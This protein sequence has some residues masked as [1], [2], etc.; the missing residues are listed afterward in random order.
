MR[1]AKFILPLLVVLMISCGQEEIYN[2]YV[3]IPESGWNKDSVINFDVIVS[4]TSVY[5]GVVVQFRHNTDYP[6]QNL[7]LNREIS[8]NGDK[9]YSD[10]VDYTLGLPTGEWIGDGFGALKSLEMP[11]KKN[12][13]R[14]NAPGT[15]RFTFEH[16][17][18]DDVLTG[19]E[20][21]GIRIITLNDETNG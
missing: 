13:L 15:Y 5:Y 8:I 3:H 16:G 1:I 6:Y 18:R 21:F 2:E 12:A 14:F 10:H 17:M 9:I 11:Y 4:D 7:W 19:L 20:D